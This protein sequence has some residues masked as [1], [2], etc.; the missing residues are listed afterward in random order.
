MSRISDKQTLLGGEYTVRSSLPQIATKVAATVVAM[1]H[2]SE[3]S[4]I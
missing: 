2:K 1:A 4:E 3:P